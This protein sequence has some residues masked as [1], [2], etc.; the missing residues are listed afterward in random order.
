MSP[1]KYVVFITLCILKRAA[2]ASQILKSFFPSL[3]SCISCLQ[4]VFYY[5]SIT[6]L[7]LIHVRY[8]HINNCIIELLYDGMVGIGTWITTLF[9]S[10]QHFISHQKKINTLYTANL[11]WLIMLFD[12]CHLFSID[13]FS[14]VQLFCLHL[15]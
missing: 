9:Y 4:V 8:V 5:L 10:D 14:H 12:L 6:C 7:S 1:Y 2:A 15:I 3:T 13:F 11:G